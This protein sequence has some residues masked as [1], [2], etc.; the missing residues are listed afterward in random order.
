MPL[1]YQLIFTV[2]LQTNIPHDRL[3][4][5]FGPAYLA[6]RQLYPLLG[7]E[8]APEHLEKASFKGLKDS[9]QAKEWLNITTKIV[10]LTSS[11]SVND[12]GRRVAQQQLNTPNRVCKSYLVLGPGKRE[13]GLVL[14]TSHAL[15]GHYSV[16]VMDSFAK[17]LIEEEFEKAI[18]STFQPEDLKLLAL[19]L[20]GSLEAA[21]NKKY[22][23]TP[24][25]ISREMKKRQTIAEYEQNPKLGTPVHQSYTERKSLM[26]NLLFQF[27]KQES[28]RILLGLKRN[29]ISPT[30]AVFASIL[31]A[32][33]RLFPD[34][35]KDSIGCML[36]FSTHAS[37]WIQ[38]EGQSGDPVISMAI[39]PSAIWIPIKAKEF[40]Q[41]DNKIVLELAKKIAEQQDKFL[42]S[43][44]SIAYASEVAQMLKNNPPTS[45][46]TQE[47][48]V[49]KKSNAVLTSQ[50][51]M[52][53]SFGHENG[54]SQIN[55]IDYNHFGRNTDPTL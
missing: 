42:Q 10:H 18:D 30:T 14:H 20:P 46:A 36:N 1:K 54:K 32:M 2:T 16:R 53:I 23:S 3:E 11:D 15:T 17:F 22:N 40:K 21:Y 26:Q 55:I 6:L 48:N 29:R 4:R 35:N 12:F 33:Q 51:P 9:Q 25:D 24:D 7:I 37:R 44:H 41:E 27:D 49:V 13:A 5:R 47:E 28:K 34:Q 19:R 50:G 43:P 8:Y 45:A 31:L 52:P 39:V 38:C